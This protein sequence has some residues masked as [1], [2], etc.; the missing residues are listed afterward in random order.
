MVQAAI[1]GVNAEAAQKRRPVSERDKKIP[2]F[3]PS[4]AA[5]T[6]LRLRALSAAHD[7]R[8]IDRSRGIPGIYDQT[9]LAH[10]LT[11]VVEGVIGQNHHTI[12]PV[13]IL[14]RRRSHP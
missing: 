12:E 1:H 10:N 2:I 14:K 8:R 7:L 9:R 4:P 5:E 6:L 13:E 11:I 3:A